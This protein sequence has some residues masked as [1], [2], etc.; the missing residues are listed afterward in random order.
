MPELPSEPLCLNCFL[1]EGKESWEV[2]ELAQDH[3]TQKW[4]SH[5]SNLYLFGFT[6]CENCC[7]FSCSAL[8]F[9]S[10]LIQS[11]Q[12]VFPWF[13]HSLSSTWDVNTLCKVWRV[14]QTRRQ[15]G[16]VGVG[17]GGLACLMLKSLF[18]REAA[19][20]LAWQWH[21][22]CSGQHFPSPLLAGWLAKLS[23]TA[24]GGPWRRQ[25]SC[26][27]QVYWLLKP[28][29][30]SLG[31]LLD[32][33]FL[34]QSIMLQRFTE[35]AWKSGTALPEWVMKRV[36]WLEGKEMK[37]VITI[38]SIRGHMRQLVFRLLCGQ[39]SWNPHSNAE[40][41]VLFDFTGQKTEIQRDHVIYP[42]SNI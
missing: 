36:L 7:C 19:D 24:M 35:T 25:E 26:Y 3:R 12:C 4:Q 29:C 33:Y 18:T 14:V 5:D 9:W 10:R 20:A 39:I 15:C 42:K 34:F 37:E 2:K 17:T 1:R 40:R 13:F 6:H 8:Q 11:G 28:Q 23:N 22:P 21:S 30:W 41:W 32:S 27:W 31:A 38:A 16:G